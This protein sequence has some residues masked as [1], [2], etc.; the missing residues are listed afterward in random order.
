GEGRVLTPEGLPFGPRVLVLG[1]GNVAVDCAR[2]AVRLGAEVQMACLEPRQAMPCH[3]EEAEAAEAEGV[4]IHP[5]RTFL[6]VVSDDHGRVTGVECAQVAHFEFG[7][8]GRLSLETVPGSEHVIEAD[9]VIFSVGQRAG[10]AFIPDDAGVGVTNQRTIAINPNT[11]A[12][13]RPGVFAAGDSVSGTAFVIEAVASGHQAAESIHRYLQ[14]EAL[15]PEPKPELPV[16]KLTRA[17]LERRVRRGEIQPTGRVP[18]VELPVAERLGGFA[19]VERGY[20][21]ASAQAEAARCLACGLCSECLSCV[22]ACGRDAIDH[23]MVERTEQIQVGAVILAPG[24]QVYRAELSQ[25]Y[26]LGRYPN[27]VTALQLERLLSASGPTGGHVQRPSDGAPARKIAFLQCVGS[28]DQSHDYCSAVCCMYAAK[29]AVMIREHD[30]EAQVHVFMMD[31]RSFSKGYQA[32]YQRARQQYGIQYTRCRISELKED[33]ETKN[34]VVRFVPDEIA[35]FGGNGKGLIA[36]PQFRLAEESF[37]LVVLSVGMEISD[38]VRQL[39]RELGVELDEYGFCSAP[40]FNPLQTSRPGI[41]AA[42][43]FREPKDIPES[44]IDASGAA[45]LA[46]GLLAPARNTLT[47]TAEYPPEREVAG[48]DARIG[49]FVCHCGSNIGGF[50]DV[51]AVSDYAGSL[52]GVVHAEHNLY[53]CS[54]DSIAHITQQAKELGLNRVVV[55]SC[56]PRT[57]APLFQ[58]SIRG[59]GLNPGLFE[60]ANIRNQCSWVHSQDWEGATHKAKDLVRMAVARAGTLQPLVTS[61]MEIEHQAL[62][63]GGGAAGMTT[64]LSLAEGGFGVH[65]VERQPELGGNLRRVYSSTDGADPQGYLQ[66]LVEKV[67]AQPLIR[68]Y[69]GH[70]VASTSGFKGKFLTRLRGPGGDEVEVAHGAT[71]LATGA[72]EYRGPEYGYEQSPRVVTGLEFEGMLVQAESGALKLEGRALEAWQ[73]LQGKLPD[74]VAMILCVGPAE[75]FCGRICCTTALKNALALKRLHPAGRITVLYRDIRAYGAKESLYTEARRAGVMFVRY[76]DTSR[77]QVE[78]RDGL[79]V[80]RA[81]DLNLGRELEL[82]PDLLVLSNPAVPSEGSK[83]LASQFKVSVDGDGFFLEAHIKL[84]PVDFATDGLFMAGMAHYP[85]L[86]DESIVQAQAAAARAS[87][88]LSQPTLTVGGSVAQVDP[89]QCVGCLTCVRACPFGV[90]Q[91]SDEQFGVGGITGA[92]FIEPTICRGCGT[93]VSECPAKAIQLAH[94]QDDQ[95]MVKL[96]AL[97]VQGTERL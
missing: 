89:A 42:G 94:Y 9:T 2:T 23:N 50:L 14:G 96:D 56:T 35:E 4:A 71:V 21:D 49:V 55:A 48:Q 3:P 40:L 62:V 54:Q 58:D 31:M 87:R 1:G 18:M 6:R 28:R 97:L 20:D 17:E 76:D 68:A 44:V 90:P 81:R 64:A 12:A 59:A 67:Q 52:P 95:I 19:E 27:V 61:Q 45:A 16:V 86:L 53:T 36:G 11:M 73:A 82:R 37:D 60:M 26:G 78:M 7:H 84:R 65:L 75:R 63:V 70:E 13:T 29:E 83:Q 25:E 66:E 80:I 79:P 15:E 38:S 46:S 34:L 85:K 24:Y 33:P 92:A 74:E 93:C 88:L 57:H 5:D 30:R 32:Y 22:Y 41:Y 39:G 77:P 69:L 10:L 43:P 47:R 51:P 91:V 8:D 72:Q